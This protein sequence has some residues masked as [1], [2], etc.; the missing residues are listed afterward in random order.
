MR[1]MVLLLFLTAILSAQRG[2]AK[3]VVEHL[4]PSQSADPDSPT[5][6]IY[7]PTRQ[8]SSAAIVICPGGGYRALALDHEGEQYAH[9]FNSLGVT[10]FVLKYRLGPKYHHPVELGDLQRAIRTV[11]ARAAEFSI[12]PNRIG[13]IGSSAGGHLA[14]SA[15]TH[16]DS[17]QPDTADPIERVSSRPD[18]AVLVYPVVTFTDEPY[19]HKGSRRSLLGDN[20]DPEVVRLMSNELQVTSQTP[21]TFMV[22]TS[23]DKSVPPENSVLY[24]LALRKAGVAAELHIYE[25]GPHGFGLGWSDI[26]LSSWPAR[27]ADWLRIRG[28]L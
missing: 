16:F 13:V 11:R 18:F 12:S 27:L 4:W 22:H 9:W 5:I 19:V 20:P 6:S 7:K 28:L 2:G 1:I 17:G 25:K 26:V 24:Y 10:G 15:S 8:T 23:E 21:P 14:S 3:P